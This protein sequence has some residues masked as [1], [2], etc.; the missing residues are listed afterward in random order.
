M[1]PARGGVALRSLEITS[2]RQFGNMDHIAAQK[3]KKRQLSEL[4]RKLSA[5]FLSKKTNTLKVHGT[6]LN[7]SAVECTLS[8]EQVGHPHDAQINNADASGTTK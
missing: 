7:E 6:R 8:N 2:S 4:T 1:R 5:H 3:L